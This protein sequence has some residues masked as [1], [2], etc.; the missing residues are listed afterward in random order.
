MWTKLIIKN[1]KSMGDKGIDI[2]LK[3]LTLLV[4]P[5]GSGKSSVLQA[6]AL[7]SGSVAQIDIRLSSELVQFSTFEEI[8]HKHETGRLLTWEIQSSEDYGVKIEYRYDSGEQRETVIFKGQDYIS[9]V[10]EGDRK[11]GWKFMINIPG[12]QPFGPYGNTFTKLS[13]NVFQ[14]LPPDSRQSII[15]NMEVTAS[16]IL[17]SIG[18]D[19]RDKVFLLSSLRGKVPPSGDTNSEFPRWVG[20]EGQGLLT[21]LSLISN[22]PLY[23]ETW[24]KIQ[25][26]AIQFGLSKL[27]A[28][29]RGRNLLSAD[30]FDPDIQTTI[31]L[32]FAGQGSRQVMSIITQLFWAQSG[33]LIMIEEP[34]LSLHPEAQYKLG[35]LFADAIK[36]G[37]QILATTHSHYFLLALNQAV[38]NGLKVEDIAVYHVTKDLKG[39]RTAPVQLSQRGY[40]L[41]WPPSYEKLEKNLARNWAK[42]LAEK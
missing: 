18:T 36:Q 23:E 21:L 33:S 9:M 29:I 39:T 2:G 15:K 30:Y 32:A 31:N 24:A 7:L 4:G 5:N 3:P 17:D 26:W 1:F 25:Y 20:T 10:I 35:A 42:G 14:T 19:L 27:K 34:E 22:T 40:P 37:K 16:N 8:A 38:E 13:G 6:L 11:K 28:G 41:S 12:Q